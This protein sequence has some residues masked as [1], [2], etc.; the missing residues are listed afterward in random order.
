MKLV[1]AVWALFAGV[2]PFTH[3]PTPRPK[4]KHLHFRSVQAS[5]EGLDGARTACG[6]A[7]SPHV[8]GL[9]SRYRCGTKITVRYGHHVVHAVTLDYGPA[10]W[11]GRDLDLWDATVRGLG[12]SSGNAYGVRRVQMALGWG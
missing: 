5:Y 8:L 11:T 10:T 2:L 6:V 7:V 12:F 1:L 3:H 9:A 4:H